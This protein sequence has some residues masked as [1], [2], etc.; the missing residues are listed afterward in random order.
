M[1]NWFKKKDVHSKNEEIIERLN[2][3]INKRIKN[4]YV[5]KQYRIWDKLQFEEKILEVLTKIKEGEQNHG[6]TEK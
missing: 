3:E 2:Q 4:C 1:F 6:K 5:A